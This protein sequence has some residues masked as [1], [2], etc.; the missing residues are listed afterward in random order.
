MDWSETVGIKK[1][2]FKPNRGTLHWRRGSQGFRREFQSFVEDF[3][4][5]FDKDLFISAMPGGSGSGETNTTSGVVGGSGNASVTLEVG[6]LEPFNTKGEAQNLS[7]RWKKWKRAFNLY[8]TGKGV[9]ND[10]QKR[11]LL[12]HVAGM[13]VQEIYFTLAGEGEGTDFEATLKV[14]DDYFVPKANIPFERHL[15]RQILQENGETVDQFVCRLHQR[16][17]TCEFAH[18]EGKNWRTELLV[19]LM[20]YRSTPQMTTGATPCY[21]MF[22]REIRSKLPELKRD[23][24]E[25]P[26]EEVQSERDWSGKLKGKTYADLK[27]G[28][29]AKNIRVGNTVLL[30]ADKTN[31]LSTNFNPAPFEVIQKTG[32]EVTLR[33][34]T[35]VELKRNTAFVKK[36][37]EQDDVSRGN[38]NGH[39]EVQAESMVQAEDSGPSRI[40]EETKVVSENSRVQPGRSEKG[41]DRAERFVR[42]SSRT[43]KQPAHF[44]N[45]FVV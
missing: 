21:M 10:T 3:V 37:N 44:K 35:G 7:Q 13:D 41:E 29:T 16:A 28:A 4:K 32:R 12:L 34:K 6:G 14:L 5:D 23:T 43:V 18:V 17:A 9:A 33:N 15:F 27:R 22:G 31:K 45:L 39:Q 42:R 40:P 30:R 1:L 11:A 26:S 2:S 8:V 25:V 20:A 38:G 19:W 24:V 36:H